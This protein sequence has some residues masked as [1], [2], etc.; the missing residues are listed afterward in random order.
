M[1][2]YSW[3]A[4]TGCERIEPLVVAAQ[5]ITCRRWCA[6][7]T[8]GAG[9]ALRGGRR[10]GTGAGAG[11]GQ[12]GKGYQQAGDQPEGDGGEAPGGGRSVPAEGLVERPATRA[13]DR[14]GRRR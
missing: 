3:L 7:T 14:D 2:V 12:G 9:R 6:A 5:A 13:G 4:Q 1:N 11:C 8:L 10:G